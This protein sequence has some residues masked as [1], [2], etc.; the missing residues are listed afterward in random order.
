M[1]KESAKFETP[2]TYAK[3]GKMQRQLLKMEKELKKLK[4]KADASQ[5]DPNA[6]VEEE[7]TKAEDAQLIEEA[8]NVEEKQAEN[9]EEEDKE[10]ECN[11]GKDHNAPK[12]E[13]SLK[14]KLQIAGTIIFTLV[15]YVIPLTFTSYLFTS[16]RSQ[17][18]HTLVNSDQLG[19]FFA[20]RLF[21]YVRWGDKDH[22]FIGFRITY[23]L[24]LYVSTV[25]ITLVQEIYTESKRKPAFQSKKKD[26]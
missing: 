19:T 10:P 4:E 18:V 2:E 24:C 1:K 3:Y 25:L 9:E 11:C 12:I 23:M 7:E 6:E 8:K 16:D 21:T 17:S 15:C 26:E 20:N 5:N 14:A 13:L 22:A